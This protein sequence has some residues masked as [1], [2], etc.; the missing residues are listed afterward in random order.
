MSTTNNK[1][2]F[3]RLDFKHPLGADVK[4]IGLDESELEH[5]IVKAAIMD[6]SAGG[7]R[8]YTDA[9][10]PDEMNLLVELK[11][12]GLGSTCR[13]LGLVVRTIRSADGHHEYCVQFSLDEPD[14]AALTSLVNQLAIKLRKATTLSN[15]SFCTEEELESFLP[16]RSGTT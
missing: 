15:C 4:V 5:K 7:A 14:T 2:S 3:F 6:L 13:L 11:F 9:P 8:F 1:R 10:L 12:I 16:L